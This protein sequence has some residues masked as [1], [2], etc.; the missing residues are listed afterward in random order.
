MHSQAVP[1]AGRTAEDMIAAALSPDVALLVFLF[2]VAPILLGVIF[3]K[4]MD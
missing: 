3:S 2:V 1:G 4:A